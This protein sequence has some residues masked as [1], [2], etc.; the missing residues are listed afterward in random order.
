LCKTFDNTI[1]LLKLGTKYDVPFLRRMAIDTLSIGFPTSLEAFDQ[2]L[3]DQPFKFEVKHAFT[4]VNLARQLDV[5]QLL[6]AALYIVSMTSIPRIL[7]GYEEENGAKPIHFLSDVNDQFLCLSAREKIFASRQNYAS[8]LQSPAR[9]AKCTQPLKCE[10]ER[11]RL[12]TETLSQMRDPLAFHYF[13]ENDVADSN[14][15]LNC[16][17]GMHPRPEQC[18]EKFW[19]DLPSFFN[20]P[21]WRMLRATSAT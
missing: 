14:F 5:P 19:E 10:K 2:G 1:A 9:S 12:H 3:P 8:F 20:L 18:R 21:N 15:C 4:I 17:D 11:H 6:P 7:F 16:L 13:W